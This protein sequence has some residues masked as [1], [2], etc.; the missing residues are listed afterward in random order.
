M[1]DST[2]RQKHNFASILPSRD[3]AD[4]LEY[5][6]CPSLL[7]DMRLR[8]HEVHPAGQLHDP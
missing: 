1:V 8:N 2:L 4:G 7:A 3:S 5:I 6:W